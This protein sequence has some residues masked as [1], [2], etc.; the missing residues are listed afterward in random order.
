M[1]RVKADYE[2]LKTMMAGLRTQAE[3]LASGLDGQGLAPVAGKVRLVAKR[4]ENICG[5]CSGLGST[6]PG[7]DDSMLKKANAE[8]VICRRLA[9]GTTGLGPLGS[10]FQRM[11]ETMTS[12]EERLK[13]LMS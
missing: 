10:Q 1:R 3:A 7:L 6:V 11:L 9:A 12:C 8:W 13:Y 2:Q 5:M 4:L